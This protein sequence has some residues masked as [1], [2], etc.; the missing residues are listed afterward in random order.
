MSQGQ[1]A[2]LRQGTS[3]LLLNALWRG[4]RERIRAQ[5]GW[6]LICLCRL[7]AQVEGLTRDSQ[8]AQIPLRNRVGPLSTS[9]LFLAS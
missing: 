6:Q 2:A 8:V 9:A 7:Q 3:L 5:G 4:L 1:V